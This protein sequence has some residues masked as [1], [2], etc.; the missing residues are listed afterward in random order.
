MQASGSLVLA[1]FSMKHSILS[2]LSINAG[3][4]L[5]LS[6]LRHQEPI[7]V[8]IFFLR[9]NTWS[10]KDISQYDSKPI[11]ENTVLG[12]WVKKV[13]RVKHKLV[14]TRQSPDAKYSTENIANNTV[15]TMYMW[16]QVGAR[17]IREITLSYINV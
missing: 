9:V 12:S 16:F 14:V 7:L 4:C 6:P 17:L 2:Y 1:S 11:K 5:N 13:K 8:G 10:E 3:L 15:M